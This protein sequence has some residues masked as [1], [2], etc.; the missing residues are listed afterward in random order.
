[1][2]DDASMRFVM[3]EGLVGWV[4]QKVQVLRLGRADEDA[5]FVARPGMR[6]RI[7]S[8]LGAPLVVGGACI[9]VIAAVSPDPSV[10]GLRDQERLMLASALCAPHVQIARL[11]HLSQVDPLT[12]ALNRR[13]FDD[14]RAPSGTPRLAIATIDL[15]HFKDVNDRFGH[16]VG[17]DVLRTVSGLL[18]SVLRRD[19]AVVRLGGEEFLLVLPGASIEDATSISER[20]RNAIETH[21]F[22]AHGT[23]FHV[24]ASIGVA[25]GPLEESMQVIVDRA[26]AAMYE[27]KRAGRNR[28][29]RAA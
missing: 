20:A 17:D 14:W 26:D 22:T 4:A 24:T 25:S 2:H 9:G 19:D 1:M 7:R 28:V 23:S 29:V 18:T 15:D 11:R 12:G 10:F 16:G 8:F 27:A 13:G 6:T 3:G 5:R 21:A